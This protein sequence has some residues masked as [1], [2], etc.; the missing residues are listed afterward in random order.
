MS[1]PRL[2]ESL[3]HEIINKMTCAPSAD[4]DQPGHL[5]SLINFHCLHVETL[6][7]KQP[8]EC[9]AKTDQTGWIAKLI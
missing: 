9:T 2:R 3:S 1:Y 7:P 8:T 6:A 4:S 5:P